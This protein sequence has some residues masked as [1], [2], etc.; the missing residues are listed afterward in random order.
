MYQLECNSVCS[1]QSASA[2]SQFANGI[3]ALTAQINSME[4]KLNTRSILSSRDR[5]QRSGGFSSSRSR[6]K[7]PGGFI[8]KNRQKFSRYKSPKFNGDRTQSSRPQSSVKATKKGSDVRFEDNPTPKV[9]QCYGCGQLGHIKTNCIFCW[10]CG[11]PNH[12]ADKCTVKTNAVKQ[13][14]VENAEGDSATQLNDSE[15]PKIVQVRSARTLQADIV[16]QGL[17]FKGFIDPGSEISIICL[18]AYKKMLENTSSLVLQ[19]TNISVSV[20]NE[21]PMVVLGGFA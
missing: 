5:R 12:R 10:R 19:P 11:G 1:V 9:P 18:V 15:S 20:A 6:S 16:I 13:L 14:S 2:P 3:A 17:P 4:T 21:S 7:S 8:S